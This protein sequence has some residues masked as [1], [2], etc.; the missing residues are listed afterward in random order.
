MPRR[1]NVT[2]KVGSLWCYV[3]EHMTKWAKVTS[4][5]NIAGT[6]VASYEI[7]RCD[8]VLGAPRV[9]RARHGQMTSKS[10]VRTHRE[11]SKVGE[12]PDR[13]TAQRVI[14]DEERSRV[15]VGQE[16]VGRAGNTKGRR[17]RVSEI[18]EDGKV[19][20]LDIVGDGH[21]TNAL[22]TT[23]LGAY[24]LDKEAPEPEPE[25]LQLP[26]HVEP[27]PDPV[28]GRLFDPKLPPAD[29]DGRVVMTPAQFDA[30]VKS[31]IYAFAEELVLN[32]EILLE[33]KAKEMN[34]SG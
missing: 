7:V 20:K 10:L 24:D 6:E 13:P 31:A 22:V 28:Q 29:K 3:A 1:Q 14:S 16:W 33:S 34:G 17:V 8:T 18:S 15:K 30:I 12:K 5:R 25:Y 11:V 9:P 4:V 26:A 32:L 23:L 27:E 2:V 19:L 21:S